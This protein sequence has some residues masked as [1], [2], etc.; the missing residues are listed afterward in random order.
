MGVT[1]AT[2]CEPG[3]AAAQSQDLLLPRFLDDSSV[4]L[5]RFQSFVAGVF[6]GT[7]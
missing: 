3:L 2:T 7:R 4:D 6:T 1:S 5:L